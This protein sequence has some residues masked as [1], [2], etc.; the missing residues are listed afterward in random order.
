MASLSDQVSSTENKHLLWS[1]LSEENIFADLRDDAVPLVMNIFETAINT[2]SNACMH[3]TH[4]H[5]NRANA[6]AEMNKDVIQRVIADV[7][8]YKASVVAP[9]HN[10][11]QTA[12]AMMYKSADLQEARVK[13]ITSKLKIHEADMNSFLV[14]KKPAEINFADDASKD[15]R[16]IGDEM[17]QLIQAAL[18]SRARELEIIQQPQPQPQPAMEPQK[19]NVSFATEQI[20]TDATDTTVEMEIGTLFGKLKRSPQQPQQQQQQQPPNN[21]SEISESNG[22]SGLFNN[23]SATT[24][25]TTPSAMDVMNDIYKLLVSVRAEIQDLRGSV[26]LI[27][28]KRTPTP[29]QSSLSDSVSSSE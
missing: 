18:A 20:L 11:V 17:E 8:K 9:P 1:L 19:K 7:S 2:T 4:G 27:A 21:S 6:L 3:I 24:P 5:H 26:K 10:H 13:D 14:L 25:T 28:E 16:P 12:P 23:F 15:D 22:S 29:N